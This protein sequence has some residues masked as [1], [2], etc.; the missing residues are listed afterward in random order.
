MEV[1]RTA[2]FSQRLQQISDIQATVRIDAAA[3]RMSRGIFGDWKALGRGVMEAR[4]HYGPGYRI[5][6][7]LCDGQVVLLLLCGDKR[8]QR[9]DIAQA[10]ILSET[11]KLER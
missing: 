5:Y 1:V 9:R 6:Y 4:I 3:Q 8:T 10:I 7:S 2:L 11:L